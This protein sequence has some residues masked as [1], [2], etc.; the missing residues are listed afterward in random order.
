MQSEGRGIRLQP[1]QAILAI[2]LR[3]S[4]VSREGLDAS[5]VPAQNEVVD[6]VSTFVSFYRLQICHVAHNGIL[7]QNSIGTVNVP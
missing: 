5:Y 1:T 7:I 3:F 6:V 4:S 2:L